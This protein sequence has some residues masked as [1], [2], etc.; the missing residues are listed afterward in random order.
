MND[1]RMLASKHI[2]VF[3]LDE[4]RY[5][6]DL[7]V[8][9]RVVQ[10]VEI[11]LLPKSPPFVMGVINVQGQIVP[12]VDIRRRL[13]LPVRDLALTDQF[14]LARTAHRLVALLVDGVEGVHELTESALVTAEDLLPGTEYI[15]GLAKLNKD[16]I[17]I[18]DL[19]QFLSLDDEQALAEI[20]AQGNA[21]FAPNASQ[22][23]GEAV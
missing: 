7:S 2:L 20:L 23:N 6:L 5:A 18:C 11:T 12:V 19:D 22:Q 1:L 17:L 4:P 13:N 16:L 10:A 15:H 21:E 3:V 8:V 9:V 14:I